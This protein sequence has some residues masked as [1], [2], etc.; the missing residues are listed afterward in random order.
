[1]TD[2][3]APYLIFSP[4][5][6]VTEKS[7]D[8]F[9]HGSSWGSN[10][11]V[12]TTFDSRRMCPRRETDRDQQWFEKTTALVYPGHNSLDFRKD[13]WLHAGELNASGTMFYCS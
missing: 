11:R 8:W 3:H 2:H 9:I 10:T 6:R 4:K 1:M 12:Q 13:A 5:L 7:A